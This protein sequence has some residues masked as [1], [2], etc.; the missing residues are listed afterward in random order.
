MGSRPL[1]DYEIKE[2]RRVFKE[3]LNYKPVRI[4]ERFELALTVAK[5][6]DKIMGRQKDP[7]SNAMTLGN[8]IVVSRHLHT[9]ETDPEES[10]LT[11]MAWLI[12]ELTHVWQ[13][14]RYKLKYL[15]QAIGAQAKRGVD[16]YKYST[17]TTLQGKGDDL[18]HKWEIDGDR[19]ESFNREQQGDIAKDFYR[20]WKKG[21][22]TTNW[23]LFLDEMRLPN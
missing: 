17:A 11:D 20:A 23:E 3:G 2:A 10:R 8:T 4:R 7:K 15:T 18:K 19:L 13:F 22:D 16:P 5:V 9:Q 6:W 12:H 21:L 1:S 14:Q